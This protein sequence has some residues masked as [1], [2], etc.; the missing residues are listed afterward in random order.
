MLTTNAKSL[1][2]R[3]TSATRSVPLRWPGEVSAISAPQSNALSA[4]RISSVAMMTKSKFLARLDRSHTRRRRGF[5]AITCNGFPGKRVE[6][7][8]AGIMPTALF[9]L[10]RAERSEVE[11][12]RG[13]WVLG[14][15]R[16][17]Q[18]GLAAYGGCVAASTSLGMAVISCFRP[19]NYLHRCWQVV[20]PPIRHGSRGVTLKSGLYSNRAY[21]CIVSALDVDL[22]I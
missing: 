13:I 20:G 17:W 7:Q 11:G 14:S 15:P 21:A 1:A 4:I 19:Q 16:D 18:G 6:L 12:S 3:A 10:S 2:W 5:P 8:R 22:A 9:M